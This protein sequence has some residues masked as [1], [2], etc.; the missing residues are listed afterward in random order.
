MYHC[1]DDSLT[2]ENQVRVRRA[3]K[4]SFFNDDGKSAVMTMS[5]LLIYI[6]TSRGNWFRGV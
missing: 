3:K 1:N 4:M 6:Q 2:V 5:L